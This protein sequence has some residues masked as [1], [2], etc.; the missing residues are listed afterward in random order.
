LRPVLTIV[1]MLDGSIDLVNV[2]AVWNDN[3][4]GSC[5]QH[6]RQRRLVTLGNA[7]H[8]HGLAFRM[9]MSSMDSTAGVYGNQLAL[10]NTRID[11]F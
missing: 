11:A 7:D 2:F 3:T 6:T 4:V 8:C 5:V 10:G 1:Y 9:V